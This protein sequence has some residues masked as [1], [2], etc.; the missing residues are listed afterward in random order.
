MTAALIGAVALLSSCDVFDSIQRPGQQIHMYGD[1]IDIHTFLQLPK[2][3]IVVQIDNTTQHFTGS[4]DVQVPVSH[5]LIITAT[6]PGYQQYEI[7][8]VLN[9]QGN[10]ELRSPLMLRSLGTQ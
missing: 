3:Q 8:T 7:R 6:A 1:A 4:Y 2:A 5:P 10:N 9:P